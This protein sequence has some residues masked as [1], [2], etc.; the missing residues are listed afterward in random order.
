VH[1]AIRKSYAQRGI[2][3]LVVMYR[4]DTSSP[5]G[6]SHALAVQLASQTLISRIGDG[7]LIFFILL[8]S[9]IS[10]ITPPFYLGR[11][12]SRAFSTTRLG[13][14]FTVPVLIFTLGRLLNVE[15]PNRIVVS[16]LDCL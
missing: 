14:G 11:K 5:I 3:Q 9:V 7:I 13:L 10:L 8:Y 4:D 6:L 2:L 12:R 16:R 15:S 1:Q